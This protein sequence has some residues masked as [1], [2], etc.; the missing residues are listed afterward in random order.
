MLSEKPWKPGAIVRLFAG[1][2]ICILIGSLIESVMQFFGSAQRERTLAYCVL[3]AG[4]LGLCA[5]ALHLLGRPW[6][7]AVTARDF[8]RLLV[9]VYGALLLAWCAVR[10]QGE[11]EAENSVQKTVLAVLCFQ[12][13]AL[14]L[15]SRFVREHG[16]G[17]SEAF[18]FNR[19]W[20]QALLLGALAAFVF[21]P[22]GWTVQA[23]SV[24]VMEQARWQPQ[25]QAAVEVLRAA[26]TWPNRLLLGAAAILVAPVAEEMMFR[27]ILYP[28]IKQA[29]YPRLAWWG[30]AL[31]FAAIHFNAVSF[32]PLVVLALMLTWLYEKTGN[33]LASII[34][35]GLF[36]GLNFVTLYLL[37]SL[38]R[39][40]AKS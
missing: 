5:G 14:L 8:L 23:A 17:W 27:G 31:A 24:W 12:G 2:L 29:G 19:G 28:A 15:I 6:R 16:I 10:L 32:L 26:S 7:L 9:C 30:T 21:L 3:M 18:G 20:K 25:E 13:A 36:N 34:T 39:L 38:G 33:L 4:A 11:I 37:E 40:P 35:H 22:F 1:V